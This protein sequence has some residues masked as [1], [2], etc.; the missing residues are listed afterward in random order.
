MEHQEDKEA[1]GWTPFSTHSSPEAAPSLWA[2]Q[3]DPR[4]E[5]PQAEGPQAEGSRVQGSRVQGPQVEMV[6]TADSRFLHTSV[7]Y[8][9][10][11]VGAT[12]D[13]GMYRQQSLLGHRRSVPGKALDCKSCRKSCR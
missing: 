8:K 5:G 6:G 1:A 9:G 7:Q 12:A 2:T 3:Q 10:S 4:A 13:N 11:I